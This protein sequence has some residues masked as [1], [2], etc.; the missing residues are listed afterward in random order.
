MVLNATSVGVGRRN[1]S[2]LCMC[3]RNCVFII[4]IIIIIIIN[5]AFFVV[6]VMFQN[7]QVVVTSFGS[8]W[9]SGG[10]HQSPDCWGSCNV[11]GKTGTRGWRVIMVSLWKMYVRMTAKCRWEAG[12]N[13]NKSRYFG[14]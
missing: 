4:I 11:Q 8:C 14:W 1:R 2:C 7:S 13:A 9:Y 3:S 5:I 12:V 10:A 6:G